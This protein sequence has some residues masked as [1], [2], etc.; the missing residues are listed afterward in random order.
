MNA[1]TRAVTNITLFVS[2]NFY[3]YLQLLS[4]IYFIHKVVENNYESES[5]VIVLH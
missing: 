2:C 5:D 1:P 3:L 4:I